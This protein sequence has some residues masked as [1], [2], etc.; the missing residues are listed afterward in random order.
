MSDHH[1]E[2][3]REAVERF[4]DS[5]SGAAREHITAAQFE[6]LQQMIQQLLSQE[7]SHI[8]ELMAAFARTLR[9]GVE[10]PDIDL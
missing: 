10:K 7:R 9:S 8:A 5:L 1:Q 4:R 3:A 2:M 6:D